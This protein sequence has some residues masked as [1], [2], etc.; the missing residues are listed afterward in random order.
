MTNHY[1]N[2]YGKEIVLAS[3]SPR[4]KE[5]LEM[6]GLDFTITPSDYQEEN[7][8]IQDPEELA[9]FHS[10]E[11]ARNVAEKYKNA[12]IIGADTI[13]LREDRVMEKPANKEAAIKMLNTLSGN[14]HI[15]YTGYTI[16][17]SS[18]GKY[19]S[20]SESTIVTFKEL[21]DEIIKYYINNYQYRDKAGSYA[22]QDFSALFVKDIVG[23]FYNVVGF[24][25]AKFSELVRNKLSTCL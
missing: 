1:L 4:R 21:N 19:L 10:L 18:N 17:N 8:E 9:I 14:V 25:V 24:P 2:F 3:Q 20:D 7:D 15:V 11:K 16:L 5:I 22:I 13:V 23:S 6:I 12:W